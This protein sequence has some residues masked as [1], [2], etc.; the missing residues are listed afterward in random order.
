LGLGDF[1]G[2]LKKSSSYDIAYHISVNSWDG[3]DTSQVEI[4][5][6]KEAN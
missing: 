6:M 4:V 3:F 1:G 2:K 5:D